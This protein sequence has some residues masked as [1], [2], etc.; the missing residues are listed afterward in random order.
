MSSAPNIRVELTAQSER[1]LLKMRKFDAMPQVRREIIAAMKPMAS[2]AKRA[3]RNAPSKR[4]SKRDSPGG[5]LRS[6]IARAITTKVR[7]SRRNIM[8]LVTVVPHGGK[9]NLA[10]AYEGEIP[11][12]HP[13]FGHDP[14]QH[15][16]PNPFFYRTLDK[17]EP[18]IA[19]RVKAVLDK[20]ERELG[21]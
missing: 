2:A 14:E 4:T 9:A 16:E 15:Q 6:A 3:V 13:T 11:W 17:Y 18:V 8:A 19:A 12:D 10:R 7:F 20:L 1:V 5:S 21:S